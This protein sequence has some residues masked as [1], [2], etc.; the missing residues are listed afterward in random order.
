MQ[1]QLHQSGGIAY[2]P[3]L[4]K[5][6]DVDTAALPDDE[7]AELETLVTE[8]EGSAEVL[9]PRAGPGG[10]RR[11]YVVRI[12]DGT[13]RSFT[14]WDPLSHSSSADLVRRLKS[15]RTLG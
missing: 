14:L 2:F 10:D 9:A 7:A 5:T 6:F 12:D 3:A 1:I 4:E 8:V 11:Q 13:P 15:Y